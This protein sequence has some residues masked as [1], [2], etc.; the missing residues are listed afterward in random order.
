VQ[1]VDGVRGDEEA[2]A[3]EED[4]GHRLRLRL[5]FIGR[6]KSE[7]SFHCDSTLSRSINVLLLLCALSLSI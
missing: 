2:M 3:K 6:L 4:R 1:A 5:R 7:A